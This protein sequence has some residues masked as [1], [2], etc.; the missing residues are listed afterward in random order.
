ME[1]GSSQA[2]L[3]ALL[4][5]YSQLKETQ[6]LVDPLLEG[7][8]W[9]LLG[10]SAFQRGEHETAVQSF[11]E[12][13]QALDQ[14]SLIQEAIAISV[15][16]GLALRKAGQLGP[17]LE[18]CHSALERAEAT[19]IASPRLQ[20][21]LWLN[22][23]VIYGDLALQ[24]DQ[25]ASKADLE[26]KTKDYFVWAV[27]A[28]FSLGERYREGLALALYGRWLMMSAQIEEAIVYLEKALEILKDIGAPEAETVQEWL[29]IC[30]RKS[31][32]E[33]SEYITKQ[34]EEII[35]HFLES[36]SKTESSSLFSNISEKEHSARR[37][38]KQEDKTERSY[39]FSNMGEKEHPV[40]Y[41]PKQE[42]IDV[43]RVHF[44]EEELSWQFSKGANRSH[45]IESLD[46][47][48]LGVQTYRLGNLKGA[49]ARFQGAVEQARHELQPDVELMALAWLSLS[50]TMIGSPEAAEYT[51]EFLSRARRLRNKYQE[52][53][54]QIRLAETVASRDPHST[55]K[56]VRPLLE[57]GKEAAR[58]QGDVFW[59]AYYLMRI[60]QYWMLQGSLANAERDFKRALDFIERVETQERKWLESEVWMQLAEV[61]IRQNQLDRAL[62]YAEMAATIAGEYGKGWEARARIVQAYVLRAG[63][64]SKESLALVESVLPV[65][66][67]YGWKRTEQE[68]LY[69][70][71]MLLLE[72]ERREEAE[73]SLR[74]ALQLADETGLKEEEI[75]CMIALGE[76][77][78]S[79]KPQ[80]AV[81]ILKK[82]HELSRQRGY[83]RYAKTAKDLLR[84][85]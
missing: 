37:L 35:R 10:I 58:R 78:L 68:A 61:A 65:L 9:N 24:A 74:R 82:A 1:A 11:R 15:N 5:N 42:E 28:Y 29:E 41:P 44:T 36:I 2:M 19:G 84:G 49:V 14:G 76:I 7:W 67:S 70:R 85:G 40:R 79:I 83:T 48:N 56:E 66:R 52:I 23:G 73:A 3:K 63:G 47:L 30:K 34:E 50:W 53:T 8:I 20:A 59:E 39:L 43:T 62:R 25:P 12:A 32:Q 18:V 54:A 38:S 27:L 60:A 6:E 51:T 72:A 17:A 46:L 26:R 4:R 80:E 71:G 75:K 31:R 55:W 77:L 16:L 81:G 22:L 33:V 45:E 69:L 13:V 57:K 21:T 64:K